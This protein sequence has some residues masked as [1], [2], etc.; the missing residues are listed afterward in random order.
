M[1]HYTLSRASPEALNDE[2]NSAFRTF[3]GALAIFIAFGD[4]EAIDFGRASAGLV[5]GQRLDMVV[6]LRL[7][8]GEA[9]SSECVGGDVHVG[10]ARLAR[11][12]V[13]LALEP[14]G[15][16]REILLR[17]VTISPI[18]EPVV[19]VSLALGCP[20]QR[21]QKFVAFADAP[22][23]ARTGAVIPV[24]QVPSDMSPNPAHSHQQP[25]TIPRDRIH[26]VQVGAGVSD[27]PNAAA[28]A[29]PNSVPPEHRP[30]PDAW[31]PPSRQNTMPAGTDIRMRELE[32]S[33]AQL[34]AEGQ[35]HLEQMAS[36]R[37]RLAEAESRAQWVPMLLGTLAVLALLVLALFSRVRILNRERDLGL[38]LQIEPPER[39]PAM[40]PVR[41]EDTSAAARLDDHPAPAPTPVPSSRLRH[42][43]PSEP[44]EPAP[45][46]VAAVMSG[47][48]REPVAQDHVDL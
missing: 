2:M 41:E 37:N 32:K 19:H 12:D 8:R 39:Q 13:R 40:A 26:P 25:D 22:G 15:D 44:T 24:A 36:M 45:F 34:R 47:T 30:L 16:D 28:Q 11:S 27:M 4:A 18:R 14:G 33:V 35:S 5:L 17:I 31:P 46:N 3:A 29:V 9:V 21:T 20:P 6:P 43:A 38:G 10:S 7:Q 1:Q 42:L 23:S 48:H